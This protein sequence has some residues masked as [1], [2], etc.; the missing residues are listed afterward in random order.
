VNQIFVDSGYWIALRDER[1]HLHA[2]ARGLAVWMLRQRAELI[3]TPF[4]FAEVQ[5]YY[6]R[7]RNIRQQVIRDIWENPVVR[8]E[9]ALPAD[10][11]EA[12]ELL[13]KHAD[14]NF[15]FCDAVS[16]ALILR[17]KIRRVV[18]FDHHFRQFGQFEVIDG[19][20]MN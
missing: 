3:V 8:V 4:I 15:S 13:K 7:M 19:S 20:E 11:Q 12:V 9:Q 16:F 5:G 2:N 14:K 1:D 10:Q 6:S 18:S 17:L